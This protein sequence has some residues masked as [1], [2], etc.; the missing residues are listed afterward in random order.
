KTSLTGRRI[1]TFAFVL[2]I[3][4]PPWALSGHASKR[5][6]L[7]SEQGLHLG[8]RLPRRGLPDPNKLINARRVR[9]GVDPHF[10]RDQH[11]IG[12]HSQLGDLCG[13]DVALGEEDF[14]NIGCRPPAWR[15]LR[16]APAET[17]IPP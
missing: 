11:I 2:I 8:Q 12:V 5:A 10:R 4:G 17:P 3:P 16:V 14:E 13:G 6:V 15:A 7:G 1:S 9:R